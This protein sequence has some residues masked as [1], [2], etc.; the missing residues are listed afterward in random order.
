MITPFWIATP[1]K[2]IKPTAEETFNVIPR[3]FNANIPP[4]KAKGTTLIIKAACRNLPQA[5]N[6]R[7][8][9]SPNAKGTTAPK[10]AYARCWFSNCPAHF[11]CTESWSYFTSLSINAFALFKNAVKS[12]PRKLT[13]TVKCR[14]FISRVIVL[15]PVVILISA[16][17]ERGIFV[18]EPVVNNRLP[19]RSGELRLASSK[20]Q[21]T[22]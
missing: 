5:A 8:S 20:R 9:I 18:P 2:A 16:T 3:T 21:I 10:R 6:N 11:K 19:I 14:L 17:C 12:T 1:T 15:A 7:S 13:R 4:N 22:S